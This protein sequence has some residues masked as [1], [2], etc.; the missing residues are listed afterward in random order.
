MPKKAQKKSSLTRYL[1]TITIFAYAVLSIAALV[2]QAKNYMLENQ[3]RNQKIFQQEVQAQAQ[4]FEYPPPP[5]IDSWVDQEVVWE[6]DR[7]PNGSPMYQ[8]YIQSSNGSK[9]RVPVNGNLYTVKVTGLLYETLDKALDDLDDYIQT[10]LRSKSWSAARSHDGS[11]ILGTNADGVGG[12][13]RSFLNIHDNKLKM[14]VI[15]HKRGPWNENPPLSLAC[16]CD[17]EIM[18]F[19]GDDVNLLDVL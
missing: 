1:L 15:S 5:K 9:K 19:L 2:Y 14:L 8:L 10:N 6:T 3:P 11:K 7:V 18:F 16:P 4:L 17:L 13:T 12:Q